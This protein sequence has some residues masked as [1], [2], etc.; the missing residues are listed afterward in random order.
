MNMK[1]KGCKNMWKAML[2]RTI[3]MHFEW[4]KQHFYRT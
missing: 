3:F 4:H 2:A 1:Y